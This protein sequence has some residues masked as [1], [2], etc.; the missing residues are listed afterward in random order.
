MVLA[1]P[2]LPEARER[3]FLNFRIFP[4][5]SFTGL[6]AYDHALSLRWKGVSRVNLIIAIY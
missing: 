6:F 3:N 1:M 4:R 5:L 2:S